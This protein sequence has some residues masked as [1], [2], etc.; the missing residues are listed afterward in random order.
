MN[1][2]KLISTW[3]ELAEETSPTH[4]LEINIKGCNGMI[5][6]KEDKLNYWDDVYYLSTHTFYGSQYKESTRVL[7]SFGFNVEIA[8]WDKE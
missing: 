7:Q 1:K 3:E 2:P 6:P 4:F 5:F 8:N